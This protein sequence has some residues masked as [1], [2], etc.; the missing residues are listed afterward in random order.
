VC[1][2]LE[3]GEEKAKEKEDG[4]TGTRGEGELTRQRRMGLA[5]VI[6]MQCDAMRCDAMRRTALMR[7]MNGSGCV[8]WQSNGWSRERLEQNSV[9]TIDQG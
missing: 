6:D 2:T 1:G 3:Q 5:V 8:V 9:N 7:S 4:G